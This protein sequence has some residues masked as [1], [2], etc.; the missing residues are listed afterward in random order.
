MD[1]KKIPDDISLLLSMKEKG[2]V[3]GIPNWV[4][5]DSFIIDFARRKNAFI[6]TN[7]RYNDY[8]QNYS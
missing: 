5:D 7:D 6:V 4:Y 2:L 8:I 1:I 3:S